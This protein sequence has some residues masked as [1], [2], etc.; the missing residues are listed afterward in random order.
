MYRILFAN[1][2][3][4][5]GGGAEARLLEI[6]VSLAAEGYTPFLVTSSEGALASRFR[7]A[8][9]ES[10]IFPPSYF[11]RREGYL[12]YYV[13]APRAMRSLLRSRAI[14]LVHTNDNRSIEPFVRATEPLGIPVVSHIT[15]MDGGW[16]SR[17]NLKFVNRTAAV[18]AVNEA[19]GSFALSHG[20]KPEILRVIYRGID[21]S[22]FGSAPKLRAK[23]REGLGISE[24]DIVVGMFARLHPRKGQ[25]DLL[26]AAGHRMLADVPLRYLL[27]GEDWEPDQSY[28]G[29]L[30]DLALQMGIGDRVNFL[31]FRE[32]APVLMS[33]CDVTAAPFRREAFGGAVAES[34]FAGTPVVGYRDGG[35]SEI[36]RDGS[37]GL[38]VEPGD[39][40]G[41][42]SAIL[43]IAT[44]SSFRHELASAAL[45]RSKEFTFERQINAI[46]ALYDEILAPAGARVG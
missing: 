20:V 26:R 46:K 27:A 40:D 2:P 3:S 45:K 10:H 7:A 39:I 24:A 33:A 4:S 19:V 30:R 44:D 37:E 41:L 23:T 6:S 32:D 5:W 18:V 17:R 12:R 25:Q 34:M 29:Y 14:N 35:I 1:R 22:K 8:G 11:L 38:L 21:A 28:E 31:G 13:A 36:V 9:V 16:F 42:A 15:D 43:R